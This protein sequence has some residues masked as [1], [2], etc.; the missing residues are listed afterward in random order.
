MQ[1]A[2]ISSEEGGAED[3]AAEMSRTK[4]EQRMAGETLLLP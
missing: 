3:Y 4:S 2:D 1:R